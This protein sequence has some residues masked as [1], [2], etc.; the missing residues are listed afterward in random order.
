MK[1]SILFYWMNIMLYSMITLYNSYIPLKLSF[2]GEARKGLLLTVSPAVSLLAP[3]LW[4]VLADRMTYRKRLL[5][6]L[7]ILSSVFFLV[8]CTN[9]S[10]PVLFS[11]ILFYA[12][13]SSSY[14]GLSDTLTL[15]HC[16]QYGLPYGRIRLMG[17]LGYGIFAVLSGALIKLSANFL[18]ALYL[19]LA[20]ATAC[21][22]LPLPEESNR[23]QAASRSRKERRPKKSQKIRPPHF[24]L[25]LFLVFAVH[26][27]LTYFYSFYSEYFV[28]QL[29]YPTWY[30]GLIVFSTVLGEIPLLIN[31]DRLTFRF[32]LKA[33]LSAAGILT[34][35]RYFLLIF[36]HSFPL[37]LLIC[38]S[39][40]YATTMAFYSA[41]KYLLKRISNQYRATGQAILYS[42]TAL[43]GIL[44]N[45]LGGMAANRFGIRNGLILSV[46]LPMAA[47]LCILGRR[48]QIQ[49]N[50]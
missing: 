1:K 2:L 25:I 23:N 18:P 11:A 12:F 6:A 3:L 30:W 22:I 15:G 16:N 4:G 19:I 32:S 44:A 24:A 35:L 50:G 37:L 7:C 13:F 46:I 9:V 43:S 28:Y 49:T 29:G 33:I 20:S 41:T 31:L 27:P 45:L 21:I 5:S 39:T 34:V 38:F 10:Y 42:V 36:L 40:G 26:F 48:F 8:I 47:T 14:G 17:T